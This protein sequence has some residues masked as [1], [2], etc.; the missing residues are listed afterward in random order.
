MVFGYF[1][2]FK[3]KP[4]YEMRISDWSSDVC[5]SDL[6]LSGARDARLSCHD[7]RSRTDIL[8]QGPPACSGRHRLSLGKRGSIA[9]HRRNA[10]QA[11]RLARLDWHR[12]IDRE[13]ADPSPDLRNGAR[14]TSRDASTDRRSDENTS[15]LQSPMR[16][17]YAVLCSK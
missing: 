14:R 12:Q 9:F 1:F 2:F 3:Q 15:E 13:R 4:A 8:G 7:D 11:F 6:A 17:S 10:W 16:I 5:S